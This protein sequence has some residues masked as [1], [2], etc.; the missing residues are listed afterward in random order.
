M[1]WCYWV[2]ETQDPQ[3]HGGYVPSLVKENESGHYPMVG[4]EKQAPWVWGK[5]LAEAQATCKA[6]NASAGI[7][8]ERAY[9]IVA[10]SMFANGITL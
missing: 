2:S 10:S 8:E 3:K 5:T 7:S 1:N 4:N 6:V 9:K